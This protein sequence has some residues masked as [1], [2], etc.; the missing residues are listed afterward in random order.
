[1]ARPKKR[2]WI[3]RIPNA[4]YFKPQGIPMHVLEEVTLTLDEVEAL[5][6]A[7]I[8]GL[9]QEEGAQSIGVSR[10]TFG[11]ILNQAH[12]KVAD[13]ILHGKALKI[14]HSD[15]I[16]DFDSTIYCSNCNETYILR[17]PVSRE[18]QCPQCHSD[19]VQFINRPG[20]GRAKKR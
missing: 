15:F 17:D 7:D 1:M 2:R 13:A 3:Y 10:A 20:R 6:L 5:R 11:R 16:E 14:E 19:E 9:S 12:A 18:R 4:L 8:E